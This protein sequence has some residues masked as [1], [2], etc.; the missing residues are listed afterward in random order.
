M[1]QVLRPT[2]LLPLIL[3]VALLA[4]LLGFA[5]IAK[6]VA[7]MTAFDK[8]VFSAYLALM[9]I[10]TV[11]RG[12][13]WHYLLRA[14]RIDAPLRAQVFAFVVGEV[15]K[16]IPVGNYVQNYLL[17]QSRG[18]DFGRSAAATT[19]I[20]LTEVAVCL[21]GV[22]VLGVAAAVLVAWAY[23]RVHRSGHWP[24]RVAEHTALRRGLEEVRQFRAGASDLFHPR[25]LVI[26]TLLG[27]IYVTLAG[28]ALYLVVR[29]LGV[30]GVSFGAVLAVSYFSLGFSLIVP[31]PLDIGVVEISALGA[32]LAVGVSKTDAVGAV[33][34]NRA[35]S[36]GTALVIALIGTAILRDEVRAALQGRGRAPG[37]AADARGGEAPTG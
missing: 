25:I 20:V 30:T 37:T 29:G 9:A 34:I 8:V 24:R 31:I 1:Q 5:D 27:A 19:L 13:Q 4:A 10:Y 21:V 18:A 14:L 36:I 26:E 35:L 32:F 17:Q 7:L 2:I 6:V 15:T 16:S 3:S 12:L 28:A 23:H 11:V 22:V 33:L